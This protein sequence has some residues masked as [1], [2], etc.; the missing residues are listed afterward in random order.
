M[1]YH[2]LPFVR[3]SASESKCSSG[4][5]I[6]SQNKRVIFKI[7]SYLLFGSSNMFCKKLE[8]LNVDGVVSL[9]QW[10][11]FT[12]TMTAEWDDHSLCVQSFIDILIVLTII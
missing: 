11:K 9:I 3:L 7:L 2:G 12:E 5:G 6:P 8:D 10:S 4:T 1:N